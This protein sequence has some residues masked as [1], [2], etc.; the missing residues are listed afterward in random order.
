MFFAVGRR[1]GSSLSSL[2][3][4]WID[5]YN[6]IGKQAASYE[7]LWHGRLQQIT[8]RVAELLL[9]GWRVGTSGGA[10]LSDAPE[11][12]QEDRHA[13]NDKE[14]AHGHDEQQD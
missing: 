7:P 8:G 6:P 3:F 1:R 13:A 9:G 5:N 11:D 10:R 14:A 4:S 2:G 12:K